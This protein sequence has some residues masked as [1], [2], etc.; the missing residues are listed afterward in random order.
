M[1]GGFE[2]LVEK[3]LQGR[4]TMS[5]WGVCV[6]VGDINGHILNSREKFEPGL[7]FE[8]WTSRSLAWCFTFE[9]SSFN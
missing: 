8:P 2:A 3:V 1:R 4:E 6:Q 7:E 9:L 5:T